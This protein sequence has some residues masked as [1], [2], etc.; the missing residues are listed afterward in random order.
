[1]KNF[2]RKYQ[3]LVA[4]GDNTALDVS[5]LRC[6]FKIEK[7]Y[8]A[9]NFAQ[10]SIY[11]LSAKTDEQI[12]KRGMRVIVNAGYQNGSYGKIFD[13]DI[14]QPIR[15]REENVDYKLT[16]HCMD[17]LSLLSNKIVKV[18]VN[19]GINQRQI[20][21]QIG[22]ES[23]DATQMGFITPDI[24]NKTLPRGKVFFGEPKKYLRQ[25]ALDNNAQFY[26]CDG[27]VHI[28]KLTDV[29]TDEAL[30]ISPQNGLIGTPQQTDDGITFRCL[31]NPNIKVINPAMSIKIDN[32]YIRQQAIRYGQEYPK[33]LS[34]DGI[35]RVAKVTF[36]GD[37]RG[38]DWYSEVLG[39]TLAGKTP[40]M[41]D[42]VFQTPN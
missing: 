7:G 5:D 20:I 33:I 27:Q 21:E 34:R 36:I 14:F 24:D 15:E 37:T 39:V 10:I 31:L 11:N 40:T 6:T 28:S 13:G 30:V 32:S 26:A 23:Y 38:E 8:Q 25:I 18:T 9:I 12:I 16:L 42:T 4:D 2:I 29:S 1:M 3:I 19:A 35:Y 17:G 41:M 22:K